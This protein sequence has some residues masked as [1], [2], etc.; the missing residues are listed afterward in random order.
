VPAATP[1]PCTALPAPLPCAG[2]AAGPSAAPPGQMP[3]A[4]TPPTEVLAAAPPLSM[5]PT[6][7][8][9]HAARGAGP[10]PVSPGQ[11]LAAPV[12]AIAV[13]AGTPPPRAAPP[14]P[15]PHVGLAVSPPPESPVQTPPAQGTK[16]RSEEVHLPTKRLRGEPAAGEVD[17]AVCDNGV[18]EVARGW[19]LSIRVDVEGRLS[20]EHPEPSDSCARTTPLCG[21][22]RI[23]RRR[24]RSKPLG[25]SI[26]FS[27]V[28]L[29]EIVLTEPS[30]PPA[31][32]LAPPRR[33]P[34]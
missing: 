10:S 34:Y 33:T 9:P 1:P 22:H 14:A 32:W 12:P 17:A 18:A 6:A 2:P 21:R 29:S 16:R 25:S 24:C 7:P 5:A 28:A 19:T 26:T 3:A 4:P 27:A 20:V 13:P 8:L 30:A 31:P 11:T 23:S 15:A